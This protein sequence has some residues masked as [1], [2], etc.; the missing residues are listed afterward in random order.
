MKRWIALTLCVLLLLSITACGKKQSLPN[1]TYPPEEENKNPVYAA[2]EVINR[3]FVTFMEE[4]DGRSLDVRSIRRAPGNANTKPEDLTKEYL[5]VINGCNITL[6]NAT[7]TTQND[8]GATLTLYQLRIVIEGGATAKERDTMFDTFAM[9]APIADPDC[10]AKNIEKAIEKMQKATESS[11]LQVSDFLDVARYI[12]IVEEH[13]V[14]CRI[15]LLA[16]NYVPLEKE[17]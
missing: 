12:P 6:R 4:Y 16:K 13:G 10:S 15:E 5:A 3:F 11:S 7:Y 1:V 8:K 14:A 2:D 9:V 17:E